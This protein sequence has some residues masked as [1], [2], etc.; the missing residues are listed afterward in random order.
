ML[1]IKAIEK[2]EGVHKAQA[3]NYCEAYCIPDGLLLNFG[4]P[5]LHFHKV[6]KKRA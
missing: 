3:I 6:F 5:S 2:I 1:E 4:T